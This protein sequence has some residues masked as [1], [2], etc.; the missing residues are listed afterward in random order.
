MTSATNRHGHAAAEP[1]AA[2]PA[3]AGRR[4]ADAQR[5]IAAI[6]DAALT[7]L[8]R[9]PEVNMVE[10][11]RTAGVGRVTLYAHFPSKEALVDAVVA[12][13]IGQADAALDAVDLDHG[14]VPQALAR[15]IASSW[16]ILNQHRQLMVAGQRHLGQ[17]RMRT[18]HDRAMARVELLISRGQT[19]GDVRTDLPRDW[20]VTTFYALLHAAA[21][22]ANAGRL[23]PVRAGDVVAST[24]VAALNP[25][26]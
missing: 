20:L 13:A 21:E 25:P 22:E 6:L 26:R 19:D 2:A 4:R 14:S 1:A 8:A 10:I 3:Q 12:H 5:N 17:T 7:C 9:G 11:A 15:L 18:H 23:D 24:V 16:Q